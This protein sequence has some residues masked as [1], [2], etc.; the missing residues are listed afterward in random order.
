MRINQNIANGAGVNDT[1]GSAKTYGTGGFPL[2]L[3]CHATGVASVVL[4]RSS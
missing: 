2:T 3:E 4:A 1:S